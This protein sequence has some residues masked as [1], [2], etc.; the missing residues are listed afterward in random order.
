MPDDV[1]RPVP[2]H[3]RG[4][5]GADLLDQV[6]EFQRAFK[7]LPRSWPDFVSG[8]AHLSRAACAE[9]LRIADAV[10]ATKDPDGWQRWV[11]DHRA[12]SGG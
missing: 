1:P 9:K 12:L 3:L 2:G 7:R 8:C 5:G 6:Y 4:D 11:R 10:G